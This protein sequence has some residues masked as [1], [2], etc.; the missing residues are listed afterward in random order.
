VVSLIDVLCDVRID[1]LVKPF[2][3]LLLFLD[4]GLV[5]HALGCHLPDLGGVR[6]T[7][8]LQRFST[9]FKLLLDVL[10]HLRLR[11]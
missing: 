6:S 10:G 9:A 11:Q 1:L 8:L 3:S 7:A 5:S 4:L 2:R